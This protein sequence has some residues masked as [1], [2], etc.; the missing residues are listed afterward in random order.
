MM[1]YFLT[2]HVVPSPQNEVFGQAKGAYINCWIEAGDR[3]RQK[4]FRPGQLKAW[5]GL[6]LN[7]LQ[8][9]KF[10]FQIMHLVPKV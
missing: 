3:K 5:T 10:I 9:M 7:C 6:L 2:Y 4:L 8:L 1:V